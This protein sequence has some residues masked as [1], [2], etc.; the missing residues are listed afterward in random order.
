M[1]HYD[2]MKGTPQGQKRPIPDLIDIT[3]D[4]VVIF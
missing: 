4:R 1:L 2:D 3:V